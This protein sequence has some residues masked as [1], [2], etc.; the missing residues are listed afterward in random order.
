M[1]PV[2]RMYTIEENKSRFECFGFRPPPGLRAI[3]VSVDW[4]SAEYEPMTRKLQTIYLY[5]SVQFSVM[6]ARELNKH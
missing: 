6:P 4:F 2:L 1:L 3:F 5:G